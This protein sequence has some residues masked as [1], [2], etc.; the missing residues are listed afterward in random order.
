MLASSKGGAYAVY[1]PRDFAERTRRVAPSAT[2][3][4]GALAARIRAEGHKVYPFS[5]GEP[6]FATPSHICDAAK[7]ALDA[8]ATHYTPVTGTAELKA[9]IVAATARDRGYRPAPNEI[10]VS[11]GV[12]HALANLALAL[13]EE[14]DE[15]VIPAPC[16]VSYPEQVRLAGA[17]PVLVHATEEQGF[18]MTPEALAGALSARTK[19]VILCSPSNPTGAAYSR[20]ELEAIA[21][22]L[23]A[24]DCWIIVD[25]IYGGLVYDGF[26][27][28]SMRAVAPDLVER[29]VIL[30]GVSKTYAMTG[31]RI[32]WSIAPPALTKQ[33]DVLQ[34][35]NTTNPAAVSQAA[36]VAALL[37]PREPV[38]AMRQAFARRRTLM[39]D[40]LRAIRGVKCRMPEGAFYAFA[41]VRAL[42]GIDVGQGAP[43][44]L[45]DDT[46][47]AMWLLEELKVATVPGSAFAA[48]GYL[49]LSYACTE[50]DIEQGLAQIAAR[51]GSAEG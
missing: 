23:R 9:A 21:E 17:T 1:M 14:G 37:G 41:D 18:R 36:A 10:A 34:G 19:A 50:S 5:M 42:L 28:A 35:Q 32:G 49:R 51:L 22:V 15:V 16:W 30:D 26:V 43:R 25:E 40:G 12:K 48:P 11:V 2:I 33:I 3:A 6:D 8:G 29:L 39:V 13:Y 38:D 46:E 45:H 7:A 20:A 31:W 44:V 27:H 4:M 24:H 47:L